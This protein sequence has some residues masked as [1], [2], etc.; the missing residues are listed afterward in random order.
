MVGLKASGPYFGAKI[1]LV[2]ILTGQIKGRYKS[3]AGVVEVDFI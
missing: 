3:K 1:V 2:P